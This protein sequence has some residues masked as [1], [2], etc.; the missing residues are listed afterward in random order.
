MERFLMGKE[1]LDVWGKSKQYN[2]KNWSFDE[3]AYEKNQNRVQC[4]RFDERKGIYSFW[5]IKMRK[6]R[7]K[8]ISEQNY[9]FIVCKLVI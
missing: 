7:K 2:Y 3:V 9:G 8:N 4:D 1:T 5:K 6:K